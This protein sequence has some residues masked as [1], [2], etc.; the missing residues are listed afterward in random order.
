MKK[1]TLD[2]ILN[3]LVLLLLIVPTIVMYSDIT[4]P[5][6][7]LNIISCLSPVYLL[8][9]NILLNKKYNDK[10]PILRSIH[11]VLLLFL[12]FVFNYFCVCNYIEVN[13]AGK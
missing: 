3:L 9:V 12:G 4:G 2:I 1:R 6:F 10:L 8:I 13:G 7:L 5:R 11:C